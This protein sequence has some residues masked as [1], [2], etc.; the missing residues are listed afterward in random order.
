MAESLFQAHFVS[1]K[2]NGEDQSFEKSWAE[3]LVGAGLERLA[4]EQ[5]AEGRE[6]LFEKLTVF[7]TG[8]ADSLPT[9]DDLAIRLRLPADLCA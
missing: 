5:K 7:L 8:S 1:G 3:V 2:Q 4:A 9:Y 6:E